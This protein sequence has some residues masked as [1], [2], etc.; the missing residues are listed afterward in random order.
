MARVGW[1]IQVRC[2][3]LSPMKTRRDFLKLAPVAGVLVAS[4]SRAAQSSAT[5]TSAAPVSGTGSGDREAWTQLAARIA[6]PVLQALADRKLKAT[7]PVEA[8]T[9]SKDRPQYTHLEAM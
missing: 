6:A 3:S 2:P 9:G 7:M 8:H 1:P 5:M 4:S